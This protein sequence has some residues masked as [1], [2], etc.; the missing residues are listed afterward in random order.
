M[1]IAVSLALRVLVP[2]LI[3][4]GLFWW[5]YES[6]IERESDRRAAIELA[7]KEQADREFEAAA[8]SARMHVL[9]AIEWERKADQ[10]YLNWQE[11]L[12]AKNDTELS[13]CVQPPSTG[14]VPACVLGAVWVGMY[15]AAWFPDEIIPES[16][17][18]IAESAV[19]SSP[20]TPREA[21]VNVRINAGLCADDRK[22]QGE[23]IEYLRE[24]QSGH[25]GQAD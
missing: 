21:L 4:C 23:L 18:G 6:G 11:K 20:A 16:P 19:G 17:G 14:S 9:A 25:A 2:L 13:A 22:R 10:Y 12:N 1:S 3:A 15:N 24:Q 7:A 5:G 8:E